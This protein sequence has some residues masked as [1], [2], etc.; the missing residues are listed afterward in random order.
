VI[1]HRGV[2]AI[3]GSVVNHSSDESLVR[4]VCQLLLSLSGDAGT[5]KAI[6]SVEGSLAAIADTM[7][8][9]WNKPAVSVPCC[10][11]LARIAMSK[12][13]HE[14]MLRANCFPAVLDIMQRAK[15]IVAVQANG[16]GV[17]AGLA[18]SVDGRSAILESESGMQVLRF[19]L[20]SYEANVEVQLFGCLA[21]SHLSRHPLYR[22]FSDLGRLLRAIEKLPASAPV[23]LYACKALFVLLADPAARTTLATG[24]GLKLVLGAMNKFSDNPELLEAAVLVLLRLASD[25][26]AAWWKSFGTSG[27]RE[28][29]RGVKSRSGSK[30][31]GLDRACS[32]FLAIMASTKHSARK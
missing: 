12:T 31:A 21:L 9:C 24:G 16:C 1:T 15:A 2:V 32:S 5:P 10:V 26:T 27:C 14:A 17:L 18:A 30:R 11:L 6:A 8:R 28:V 13:C 23:V 3:A 19:S 29:V 25:R 4:R 22:P 7:A 20:D